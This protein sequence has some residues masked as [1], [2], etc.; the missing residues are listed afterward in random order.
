MYTRVIGEALCIDL[1]VSVCV[2]ASKIASKVFPAKMIYNSSLDWLLQS[3][4]CVLLSVNRVPT[5][6]FVCFGKSRQLRIQI[7]GL[8][9][10]FCQSLEITRLV[11]SWHTKNSNGDASDVAELL[12]L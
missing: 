12:A 5:V 1:R 11:L 7:G 4:R 6:R 2:V 3:V 8:S 9:S 10:D